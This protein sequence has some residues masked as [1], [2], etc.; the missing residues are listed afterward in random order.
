MKYSKKYNNTRHS[1]IKMTPT[2]ASKHKNSKHVFANLYRDLLYSQHDSAQFSVGDRVRISK[3]KRPVFDKGYTP[4]WTEEIFV[5]DKVLNTNPITY[6][7]TD[8]MGEEVSGS[9]YQQEL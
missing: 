2:E 8:L 9:F 4:N 7:L 1:A 6:R 3:Y 5:I